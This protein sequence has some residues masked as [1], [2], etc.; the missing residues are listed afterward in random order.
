MYVHD[1]YSTVSLVLLVSFSFQHLAFTSAV[2]ENVILQGSEGLKEHL[3]Y[4]HE[5]TTLQHRE[6]TNSISLHTRSFRTYMTTDTVLEEHLVHRF[7][8]GCQL[9]RHHAHQM[10]CRH[11][12]RPNT[13]AV[14][15]CEDENST[16][17]QITGNDVPYYVVSYPR[18]E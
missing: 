16:F 11:C 7:W 14:I 6:C 12:T 5:T 8:E 17:L 15:L 13:T 2:Q 10:Y 1:S 4:N 3:E 9:P 18:R